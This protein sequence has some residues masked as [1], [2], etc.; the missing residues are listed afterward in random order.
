MAICVLMFCIFHVFSLVTVS[1]FFCDLI[2][3][4]ISAVTECFCSFLIPVLCR[5]L[6]LINFNLSTSFGGLIIQFCVANGACFVRHWPFIGDSCH[7]GF[8]LVQGFVGS[9]NFQFVRRSS[10]IGGVCRREV[11][12]AQSFVGN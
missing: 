10:N 12:L 4:G 2:S 7:R 6:R 1:S 5:T 11:T 8:K 9:Q 3:L